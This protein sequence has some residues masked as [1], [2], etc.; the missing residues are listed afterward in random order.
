MKNRAAR[1]RLAQETVI[2]LHEGKYQ[3]PSGQTVH[4]KDA[5][6]TSIHTTRL[7]RPADWRSITR[8]ARNAPK[9]GRPAKIEIT[10]ETTLAA[11]HRLAVTHSL[12][13]VAA[14]NFASG[15]SPG[16]GFLGGAYAQE[17]SLASATGLYATLLPQTAYYHLNRSHIPL[18]T[19]HAI[20][21]PA[22]PIIRDD[23]GNLLE[24]PHTATF[25][26]MPAPN[27]RHAPPDSP[28][29]AEALPILQRRINCVFALAAANEIKTLILGAWGCGAFRNDPDTVAQLFAQSLSGPDSWRPH[30]HQI[31]FAIYDSGPT[32][33]NRPPFQHHL[34]HLLT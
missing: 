5:L 6:D 32:P 33:T 7:I 1:T 14:L 31:T 12:D 16:G 2:I 19:D 18:Y 13:N 22:V 28:E 11:L 24:S 3:S 29:V 17:E 8:T 20:L 10:S 9:P 26:T 4:I 15:V 23:E 27:L 30:F 25:I 34:A 21:S